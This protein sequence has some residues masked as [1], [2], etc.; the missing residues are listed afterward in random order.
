MAKE[1]SYH[2]QVL[3]LSL[4]L[5]PANQFPF[6]AREGLKLLSYK[7]APSVFL[8]YFWQAIWSLNTYIQPQISRH[9]FNCLLDIYSLIS[10]RH[11]KCNAAQTELLIFC[12]PNR[13]TVSLPLE[14]TLQFSPLLRWKAPDSWIPLFLSNH[15]WASHITKVCSRLSISYYHSCPSHHHLLSGP[16]QSSPNWSFNL[17]YINSF[18][19]HQPGWLFCKYK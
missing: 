5:R 13:A 1:N 19:T 2:R 15:T 14:M 6:R 4:V 9:I 3:L 10:S 7:P 11:L 18:S 8:H 12:S 17:F 16:L